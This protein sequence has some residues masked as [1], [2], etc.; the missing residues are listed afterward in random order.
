MSGCGWP[1]P[2]KGATAHL[3]RVLPASTK[4]KEWNIMALGEADSNFFHF[5]RFANDLDIHGSAADLAVLDG[6][7]IALRG[8]S[9]RGDDFSAMRALDL[10]FDEHDSI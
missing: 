6:R 10:N 9:R 3:T 1:W 8:I 2:G 4:R 5:S 7:V